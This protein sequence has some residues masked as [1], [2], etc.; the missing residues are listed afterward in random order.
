VHEDLAVTGNNQPVFFV[1]TLRNYRAKIVYL[2][3][4]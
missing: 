2:R 1:T 3:L 4:V